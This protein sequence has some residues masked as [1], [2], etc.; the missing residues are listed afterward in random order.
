MQSTGDVAPA[1]RTALPLV[2]AGRRTAE[3]EVLLLQRYPDDPDEERERCQARHEPG[4][5]VSVGAPEEPARDRREE[6]VRHIH[7]AQR[8][9]LMRA[10]A[11]RETN[12]VSSEQLVERGRFGQVV[13]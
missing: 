12:T 7:V 2:D 6:D 3:R 9:L 8:R 1:G 13:G 5:T 10:G 11:H 4:K